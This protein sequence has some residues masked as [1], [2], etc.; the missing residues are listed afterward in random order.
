MS[1]TLVGTVEVRGTRAVCVRPDGRVH[2]GTFP[3]FG[4]LRRYDAGKRIYLVGGV[5]Q[6]ENDAQLAAR[7][8]AQA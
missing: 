6:I 5:H 7:R 8:A 4:G 2:P 1:R 3:C